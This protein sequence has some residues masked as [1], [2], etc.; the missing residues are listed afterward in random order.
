[1]KSLGMTSTI[2]IIPRLSVTFRLYSCLLCRHVLRFFLHSKTEGQAASQALK[3]SLHPLPYALIITA[4]EDLIHVI[5]SR[6]VSS[7]TAGYYS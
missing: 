1:M 7:R 4:A 5:S 2:S 6:I 3:T